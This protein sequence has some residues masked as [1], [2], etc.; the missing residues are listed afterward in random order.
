MHA[1]HRSELDQELVR[2][3]AKIWIIKKFRVPVVL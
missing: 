1:S 2:G 3:R